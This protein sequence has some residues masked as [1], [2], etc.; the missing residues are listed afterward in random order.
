[1]EIADVHGWEQWLA[2]ADDGGPPPAQARMLVA[3]FTGQ[4]LGSI[5][6]A[7]P[8]PTFAAIGPEGGFTD[9]E[10][11]VAVAAGW[12]LVTLGPRILRVET[13]AL[14]LAALITELTG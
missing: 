5:D 14:A 9:A 10:I 13:A 6:L 4:P 3:H 2:L 8:Q 12:R 11:A 7:K 1:M